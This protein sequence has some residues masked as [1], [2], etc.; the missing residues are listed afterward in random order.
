MPSVVGSRIVV[1]EGSM[2]KLVDI[3]HTSLEAVRIGALPVVNRFLS[4][5]G[6]RSLLEEYVPADP[7]ATLAYADL[8]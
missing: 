2:G 7:R 3:E 8:R 5:L 6:L 1:K 4:R